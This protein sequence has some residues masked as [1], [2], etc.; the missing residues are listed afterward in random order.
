M[1]TAGPD[2]DPD[3]RALLEGYRPQPGVY[4]ECVDGDGRP[5]A[6]WRP[7]LERLAAVAPAARDDLQ[8]SLTR[9]LQAS[10]VAFNVYARPDDRKAAWDLDLMPVILSGDDWRLLLAAVA[11]RVR[12]AERVFDDLY[13]PQRLLRE[14]VLPP[15]AV[16][17]NAEFLSACAGWDRPPPNAIATYAID[18]AR[19]ADGRWVLLADQ[20]DAPTGQG[21]VLASRIALAQTLGPL[22]LQS[23]VRRLAGYAAQLNEC[24]LRAAGDEGRA[25]LLSAGPEDANYFSHAFLARYL[26]LQL[27]ETQDLTQRDGRLYLKTLEG[28]QSVGAILRKRPGRELDPLA[29]PGFGGTGTPGLLDTARLGHVRV[30][31]AIGAG[32]VQNRAMAPFAAALAR[33]LLDEAPVLGEAPFRWLGDAASRFEVMGSP[34]WQVTS[35][36]A[37]QDPGAIEGAKP[38]TEPGPV[39][40]RQLVREGHRWIAQRPL[41]LATTPCWRAGRLEPMPWAMRLFACVVDDRVHVLPAGLGRLSPR[42]ATVGLPSGAG[43]KDVWVLAEPA[44]P[45]WP[46][47][48]SHRME[49]V[50]LQREARDLLSGTAEALFWLGRY[51]ER[52]E[53]T[54]RTLRAVLVRLMDAGAA[55]ATANLMLHLAAVHLQGPPAGETPAERL[56][57]ALVEL[58]QKPDSPHAI[59]ACIG[60]IQRNATLARGV[61]SQD[62]WSALTALVNDRRWRQSLGPVLVQPPL[63]LVDDAIRLLVAFSGTVAE[64]MTRN[65]AWRF[66]EIGKRLERALQVSDVVGT[67]VRPPETADVEAALAALLEIGDSYMTYRSRYVTLPMTVPVLDLLLLDETNPRGLIYQTLMLEQALLDLPSEGIYRTPAQRRVLELNTRLRLVDA[68][69]LDPTVDPQP[70]A[71]LLGDVNRALQA[72]SDHLHRAYFLLAERATTTFSG[73]GLSR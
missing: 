16:F 71:A 10:G 48:L 13:G 67:G 12:L 36:T 19:Q 3:V 27:V 45:P 24:L 51:T 62:S 26:G 52:A 22:F 18:V 69:A 60:A 33:A 32:V 28:L 25:V 64:H 15:A 57:A 7:F 39:L 17:G 54:L 41:P 47:L 66:L 73:R 20:A 63:D 49:R 37:R 23:G 55:A 53:S 9:R 72:T 59:A 70:L 50:R 11:Q 2:L 21:W 65:D 4:D 46:T 34:A 40:A 44:E 8:R 6:H 5:R 38:S 14:R 30:L 58:L 29:V 56:A 31:N 61:L 43:S 68:M 42:P 1:A 35:L